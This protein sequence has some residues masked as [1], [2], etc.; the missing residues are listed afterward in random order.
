MFQP[1]CKNV[2]E[3]QKKIG[4]QFFFKN[5]KKQSRSPEGLRVGLLVV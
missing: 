2:Q 3:K 1:P 4:F 5:K